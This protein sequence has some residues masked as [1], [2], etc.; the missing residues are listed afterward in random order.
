MSSHREAPE[1]SKDPVADS[2]DI[3]AFVSPDRPTPSRSS[4]T[5]SRCRSRTAARTSTSSATTCCTR[6]TI[7]NTGD[8]HAD[9]VY[10]FRF[11]TKVA[12]PEDVP[13]Q[14]R[15]RSRDH[16]HRTGTGRRSTPSPGSR[17]QQQGPGQG[18]AVPPVNVGKRSTPDYAA[19][20]RARPCTR[21]AAAR[22]SP[23][24]EPTRFYVDLGSVFDL[25]GL[26]PFNQAHLIPL[27]QMDGVN[28]V[29]SFNVHTIAIQVPITE[30][31]R[32]GNKPTDV[33]AAD[34]VIGV[35]STA[36]RRTV[37]DPRQV[38]GQVRGTRSAASGLPAGQ[39]AVQRGDRADG[40][41]GRVERPA[42]RVRRGVREV[43]A[44]AGA[45]EA[46]A[47]AL[48]GCVP[49]PEGVHEATRGPG[50]DPADRDPGRGRRGVPELH[51]AA[52]RPTCSG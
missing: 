36:R 38:H 4:P 5:T 8:G 30:L 12:Q 15:A 40:A 43:R 42:A 51:R 27:A 1:I 47:G 25:G 22:C 2:T 26:R 28:S 19:P 10:K 21:S 23:A 50:G 29:R 31:T 44:A 16:R 35:W 45:R 32:N 24:S 11:T 20:R 37:A 49:E 18:L 3:Y 7:G 17:R 41:E 34:S 39:P 48:P 33:M 52:G 14:H 46:A 13:L 6:S 9:I